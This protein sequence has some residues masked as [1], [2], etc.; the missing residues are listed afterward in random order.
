MGGATAE[1]GQVEITLDNI[2]SIKADQK[3]SVVIHKRAGGFS[4]TNDRGEELDSAPGTGLNGATFA[5]YKVDGIDLTTREGWDAYSK[6]DLKNPTKPAG[7]ALTTITTAG[8]G[9]AT[10]GNLDLGVY[11]V[12]ETATPAGHTSAKPFYVVVPT[13]KENNTD[14][15][16]DI[17]VYPKNQEVKPEKKVID[18]T[19]GKPAQAKQTI[20]YELSGDVPPIPSTHSGNYFDNYELVDTY[21]SRWTPDFNTLKVKAGETELTANTDY[22]VTEAGKTTPTVAGGPVGTQVEANQF[23]IKFTEAGLRKLETEARKNPGANSKVTATISGTLAEG[24]TGEVPNKLQLI[25][26]NVANP[27]HRVTDVP[28]SKVQSKYGKIDISKVEKG[29]ENGLKGATF[30]LY[31]CE[32]GSNKKIDD[33]KQTVGGAT[34][35]TTGED[36]KISITGIQLEDWANN[37]AGS[38]APIKDEFDYCLIET[39][40]PEG[41][42]KL[43]DPIPVPVNTTSANA[44][45]SWT[46]ATQIGNAKTTVTTFKLPS[47]GEWGRWWLVLGGVA[48]VL[49]ALGVLYRNNRRDNA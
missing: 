22:T 34:E 36:G 3:G 38:V 6:L 17:H 43:S 19:D 26:P 11:Y 48:A 12:E 14:W 1:A 7:D 4:G 46:V 31:K 13:L 27:G 18:R 28:E 8:D 35:W 39:K 49:A 25:P 45:N 41:Y 30:E 24:T 16:Y 32:Q 29:T 10:A 42:D 44:E 20:S 9:E 2:N 33:S 5:L 15:N 40:A 47:T 37:V 23:I 21:D